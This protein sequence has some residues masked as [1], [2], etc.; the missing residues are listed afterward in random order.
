MEHQF[1]FMTPKERLIFQAK[2]RA[3]IMESSCL[4]I[5]QPVTFPKS[6]PKWSLDE[7]KIT[8]QG[9]IQEL[10]IQE[11]SVLFLASLDNSSTG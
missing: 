1:S 5:F 6:F 9:K 11:L 4:A 3:L 2:F 8:L 10:W 7:A